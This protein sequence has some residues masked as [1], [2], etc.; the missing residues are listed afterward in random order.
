M[1]NDSFLDTLAIVSFVVGMANYSENLTQSDKDDIMKTLDQQTRDIL[2]KI[3]ESLER[4]NE[5]LREIL[6]RLE[7][8]K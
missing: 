5:M 8:H 3:E 6:D 4:Q 1:L 7:D 2:T